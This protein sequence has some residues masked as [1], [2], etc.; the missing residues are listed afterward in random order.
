MRLLPAKYNIEDDNVDNFCLEIAFR[1]AD[2]RDDRPFFFNGGP[3]DKR[4]IN[5]LIFS[6]RDLIEKR[7]DFLEI[8]V[9]C[10]IIAGWDLDPNLVDYNVWWSRVPYSECHGGNL[11]WTNEWPVDLLDY[12]R[13]DEIPEELRVNGERLGL[14]NHLMKQKELNNEI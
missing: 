10:M 3:H 11:P 1:V 13:E 7:S 4:E 14:L 9:N 2:E 12:L 8:V 6:L 5:S